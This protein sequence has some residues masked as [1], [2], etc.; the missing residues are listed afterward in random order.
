MISGHEGGTSAAV[1]RATGPQAK[2][3]L[4]VDERWV[5]H[6]FASGAGDERAFES[7]LTA[8]KNR[9][10]DAPAA[11]SA[12]ELEHCSLHV[13]VEGLSLLAAR[14]VEDSRSVSTLVPPVAL[15]AEGAVEALGFDPGVREKI[16]HATRALDAAYAQLTARAA[17]RIAARDDVS[18]DV[19]ADAAH[20]LAIGVLPAATRTRVYLTASA[21]VLSAHCRKLLS[22]PLP[23]VRAAAAAIFNAART[24]LPTAFS[25]AHGSPMREAAAVELANAVGR[26][27]SAPVEGSSATMVISQPV[28]LIR[29]DKDAL[30]RVMLA[31]AYD[32]S[33]ASVNAFALIGSLRSAKE[34]QV[35]DVLRAVLQKRASDELV[36]RGFEA[37]SMSF[38]IMADAATLFDLLRPRAHTATTQR[39]TCRLGFQM[40]EDLLDLGLAE[41]YQDAM[42]GALATWQEIDALSP[43]AAEYAVPLGY[44]LRSLWTVDLRQ[45]LYVIESRS[46]K[47]NP[48]RVRRIAHGLYR[49][50][51]A[52]LPWLREVAR[53]DLD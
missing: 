36:P 3:V 20:N 8:C 29:H 19:A 32:A 38:E 14:A 43:I 11:R 6:V 47:S 18:A 49:T 5:P 33:D 9:G 31:M 39:L 42:L 15:A 25:V 1:E 16:R 28:R 37:A 34:A 51:G 26:L 45:L 48:M 23:E 21:R 53:V 46:A 35:L 10:G 50:A 40:P 4:G 52:V 41:L 12:E 22:H 2:A 13:A 7:A 30:E 44:R 24:A 27:Y 17:E